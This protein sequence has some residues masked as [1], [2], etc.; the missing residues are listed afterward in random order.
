MNQLK[1]K[2]RII[3]IIGI[4]IISI[5]II[6]YVYTKDGNNFEIIEENVLIPEEEKILEDEGNVNEDETIKEVEEKNIMVHITGAVKNEGVV[7][8]DSDSRVINAIEEAG[9]ATQEADLSKINLVFTL[10]DGMK[11]YIPSIYDDENIENEIEE[12][13]YITKSSDEIISEQSSKEAESKVNI[14]KATQTELETLP[15]IGPSTALKIIEY[16]ENEG[17]FKKIEDIKEVSG[18]GEAKFEKIKDFI[19]I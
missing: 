13:E 8:L 12:D 4:I 17:K 1:T 2:Q 7:Y 10:E 5:F 15:G 18:I 3:L 19:E 6:Y 16:R 14:N 9:G 11:I